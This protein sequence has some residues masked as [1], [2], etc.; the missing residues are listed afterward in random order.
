ME[1]SGSLKAQQRASQFA[2]LLLCILYRSLGLTE[3]AYLA[4]IYSLIWRLCATL[5]AIASTGCDLEVFDLV[6]KPDSETLR[7][8]NSTLNDHIL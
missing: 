4:K 3:W 5:I 1:T 8:R 7:L 2:Y 6:N